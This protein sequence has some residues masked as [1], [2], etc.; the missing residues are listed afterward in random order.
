NILGNPSSGL[1][2]LDQEGS[3]GFGGDDSGISVMYAQSH[4]NDNANRRELQ[5]GLYLTRAGL[6]SVYTDGN[7]QSQTLSQSGGAFPRHA[8]TSFLRQFS[9][10]RIRNLL[11]IHNQFARGYQVGKWSDGDFVAYEQRGKAEGREE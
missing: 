6:G 8:N 1:Q 2:G 5:L 9:D 10:N 11:Y 3:Y 4:D 7:H